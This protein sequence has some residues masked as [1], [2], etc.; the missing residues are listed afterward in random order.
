MVIS[1]KIARY[2]QPCLEQDMYN[3]NDDLI[4]NRVSNHEDY[5]FN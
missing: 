3:K 4:Y 2:L 5:T 1:A